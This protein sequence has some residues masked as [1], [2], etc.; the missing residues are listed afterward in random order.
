[1][2]DGTHHAWNKINLL[3]KKRQTWIRQKI[4]MDDTNESTNTGDGH[5]ENNQATSGDT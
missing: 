5:Q 1:M 3:E 4:K 2:D